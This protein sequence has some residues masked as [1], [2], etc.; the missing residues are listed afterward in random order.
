MQNAKNL[1]WLDMEMT[2]LNPDTDRI[3]EVAMIITDSDLNILAQSEVLVIHQPDSI[4]DHMDKWNTTTH[5]RTGLVDKVKASTLTETEAEEKLLAFISEW[6]PEKASPMCGNSIH[7]DRRFMV[8]YMPRLEAYF[9]YRN[10]DV[11][12]LK[13][14]ARR[15]N[16]AIVKGISKKGA[17][18][19]LDDIKES[20]EEMA[21][22]REHFL[23][24]PS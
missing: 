8:R 5:T 2:G 3:I 11:S 1:A 13:E 6:I 18:Q 15:W 23:T 12:T 10:L 7:Q 21:Y 17:H 19:A 4:I 14:L 20:I 9:H 16:P 24:I 22:Y